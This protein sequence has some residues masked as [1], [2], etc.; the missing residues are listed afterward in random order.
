MIWVIPYQKVK[1]MVTRPVQ[2]CDFFMYN[3]PITRLVV[4]NDHY[5]NYIVICFC[6]AFFIVKTY[7]KNMYN[8]KC[9]N[10]AAVSTYKLKQSID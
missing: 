8:S 10:R 1:Y 6:V 4:Q 3:L 2:K 5:L 9:R 7:Q